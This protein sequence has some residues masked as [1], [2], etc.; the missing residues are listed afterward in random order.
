MEKEQ[1]KKVQVLDFIREHDN[2]EELLSKEPYNIIIKWKKPFVLLKYNQYESD[3]GN[4]I[5]QECRGLILKEDKEEKF[6]IAS[7][8]F[9]KFFNYGEDKASKL[10][11]D[12]YVEV[13]QKIDGSIIGVW[14]DQITGWHVSTSGNIDAQDADLQFQTDVLKNYYDLFKEAALNTNFQ[15]KFLQPQYTYIFE[16]VSP[17]NKTVVPYPEPDLY[18]LAV[19]DNNTLEEVSRDVLNFMGSVLNVKTPKYF[20]C[21]N[22]KEAKEAVSKLTKNSEHFEGFVLCDKH[23]NRIKMKTPCYMELFFMKGE[24]IM[25]EKKILKII[26]DEADDDF[27][28]AFPEYKKEFNEIKNA[29]NNFTNKMKEALNIAGKFKSGDRKTYASEVC[30]SPFADVLFKAYDIDYWDKA[31]P[32]QNEFVIDYINNIHLSKLVERIKEEL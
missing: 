7:M 17:Y 2:W 6:K 24:G 23:F 10:D 12:P 1:R 31:K 9:S 19:R 30:R 22:I 25:S 16:L 5:V 21:T 13:Q 15:T 32:E 20:S 14:Y 11:F 3:F 4:P 8:R 27:I 29:F 26:L 18:L 28:S